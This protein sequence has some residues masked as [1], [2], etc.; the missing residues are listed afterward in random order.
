MAD[1]AG[2]VPANASGAPSLVVMAKPDALVVA[3]PSGAEV[4]LWQIAE[5]A[6][7]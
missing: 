4:G 7:G 1:D 6:D 3:D 5:R 2:T